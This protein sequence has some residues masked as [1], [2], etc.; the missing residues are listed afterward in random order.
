MSS[1]S[2]AGLGMLTSIMSEKW[3]APKCTHPPPSASTAVVPL[4]ATEAAWKECTL[5]ADRQRNLIMAGDEVCDTVDGEQ[6]LQRQG[7][8]SCFHEQ[9]S[10]AGQPLKFCVG[11]DGKSNKPDKHQVISCFRS[12]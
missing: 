9:P 8:V 11:P 2:T 1:S 12:Q 5:Q 6:L 3:A 4:M 7:V 10:R